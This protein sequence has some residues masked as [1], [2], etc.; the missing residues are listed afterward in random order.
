M[1]SESKWA[2][3]SPSESKQ[4]Q[5]SWSEFKW[6]Q[7]CS[8]ES[9]EFEWVQSIASEFK[10]IQVSSSEF[11]WGR[12][13]S[14]DSKWVQVGPSGFQWVHPSAFKRTQVMPSG[15][16]WCP[17]SQQYFIPTLVGI[18]CI[19]THIV[20]AWVPDSGTNYT[21]EHKLNCSQELH[22]WMY[23]V[24]ALCVWIWLYLL[25]VHMIS[26]R[27]M[28][29]LI[30]KCS[31]AV[32]NHAHNGISTGVSVDNLLGVLFL[33]VEDLPAHPRGCHIFCQGALPII[34]H[35]FGIESSQVFEC[36]CHYQADSQLTKSKGG[37]ESHVILICCLLSNSFNLAEIHGMGYM[38]YL[39]G[40][41]RNSGVTDRIT[42]HQ[43]RPLVPNVMRTNHHTA[44]S[45]L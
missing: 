44:H 10:R 30:N 40:N 39:A 32:D 42:G 22:V 33:C 5:V 45:Q 43:V 29:V 37:G 41:S 34:R 18:A 35:R 27:I 24:C 19:C 15:F 31:C 12:V 2:Q 26:M 25:L 23:V 3:V 17:T 38:V 6:V 16:K 7:G 11:R 20:H 36:G 28:L 1:W 8:T 4:D 21:F 13:R 14:G 9:T